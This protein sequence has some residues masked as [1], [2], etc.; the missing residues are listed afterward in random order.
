MVLA[1]Y[2]PEWFQKKMQGWEAAINHYLRTG[3]LISAAGWE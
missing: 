3:A 2:T 1:R